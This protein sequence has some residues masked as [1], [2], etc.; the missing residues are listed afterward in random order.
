MRVG[1]KLFGGFALV[2]F[3]TLVVVGCRFGSSSG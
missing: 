2:V 1:T 3:L